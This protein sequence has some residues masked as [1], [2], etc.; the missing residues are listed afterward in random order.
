MPFSKTEAITLTHGFITKAFDA[1]VKSYASITP[2]QTGQPNV[3]SMIYADE[4]TCSYIAKASYDITFGARSIEQAVFKDVQI[5][6]VERFVEES[7]LN[8]AHRGASHEMSAVVVGSRENG[9]SVT[10]IRG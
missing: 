10:H 8:A 1:L 9:V 4:Q 2:V 6:M 5:Q 7:D 3:H